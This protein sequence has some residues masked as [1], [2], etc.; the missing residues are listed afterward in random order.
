[1]QETETTYLCLLK[2]EQDISSLGSCL[3]NDS[4]YNGP[5]NDFHGRFEVDLKQGAH[6]VHFTLRDWR[7]AFS[8]SRNRYFAFPRSFLYPLY[9]SFQVCWR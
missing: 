3:A 1:M 8:R 2:V 5:E 6:Q 9:G 4:E 7:D